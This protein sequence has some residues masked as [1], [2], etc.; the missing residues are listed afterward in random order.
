MNGVMHDSPEALYRLA[1]YLECFFH[2]DEG[3]DMAYETW[4]DEG[5]AP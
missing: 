4:R 3:D 2:R 1:F 5:G